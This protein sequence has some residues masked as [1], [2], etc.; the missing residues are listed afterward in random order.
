MDG[1]VCMSVCELCIWQK[2]VHDE[3]HICLTI[4]CLPLFAISFS[5]THTHTDTHIHVYRKIVE[6]AS[7]FIDAFLSGT[8]SHIIS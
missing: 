8:Y 4:V 2:C 6:L 5:H 3:E 1:Y 7:F